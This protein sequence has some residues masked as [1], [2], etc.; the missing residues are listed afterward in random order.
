MNKL[1]AAMLLS[2]AL[3]GCVTTAPAPYGNF[4]EGKG[5]ATIASDTVAQLVKLYPPAKTR[6]VLQ[7]PA[8]ED[9]F[10]AALVKGLRA[11]GYAISIHAPVKG[12]QPETEGVQLSYV[13]DKAGDNLYISLRFNPH[14]SS[15]RPQVGDIQKYSMENKTSEQALSRAYLRRGGELLPAGY[16]AWRE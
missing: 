7:Q 13:L 15:G 1:I 12:R 9:A 4:I 10:G 11:E 8:A 2:I 6:F 16:W 3:S 14:P 5:Q